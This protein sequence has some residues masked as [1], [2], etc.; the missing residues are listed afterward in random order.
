M[1][2]MIFIQNFQ[3]RQLL[4]K[5]NQISKSI[6][7]LLYALATRSK[8]QIH[9]LHK[10]LIKYIC[11]EKIKTE[12]QLLAAIDYLLTN[13]QEPVDVKALEESAGVGVVV[14]PADIER[15]IEQVIGENKS[16]LL[17]QRYSFSVGTLLAEVRKRLK[18][19]DGKAV[20]AE[21]DVQV[22]GN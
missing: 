19:A 22:R 20:K 18:W 7:N 12:Q 11:D 5:E 15:V 3:A 2:T 16:K 10:Y 1:T 9:S 6:G 21:M 4:P 13:P 17:E 8:Q 14:T